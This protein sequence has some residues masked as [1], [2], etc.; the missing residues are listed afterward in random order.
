MND[1]EK[2]KKVYEILKTVLIKQIS[3]REGIDKLISEGGLSEGYAEI[4]IGIFHKLYN[5]EEFKRTL[6]AQLL[7][8]L[9]NN[10]LNDQGKERLE[11]ALF[12]LRKHLDYRRLKKESKLSRIYQ[13]YLYIVEENAMI[14]DFQKF[15]N[16]AKDDEL[17][18]IQVWINQRKNQNKFKLS[19]LKKYNSQCL[20]SKI[21]IPELI[22]AAHIFPHSKS[23]QN[24]IANGILLRS[25]LHTLFDC[26]LLSINPENFKVIIDKS[27]QKTEYQKFHDLKVDLCEES[28][29]FLLLKYSHCPNDRK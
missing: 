9:L 15:I 3:R 14:D 5:G 13:D 11:I 7:D 26:G 6:G 29:E 19:L 17:Q 21:K 10:L 25:D 18:K 16:E 24:N 20:I 8:D 2:N 4:L 23:G 27:L 22:E 28:K 1:S 12:G